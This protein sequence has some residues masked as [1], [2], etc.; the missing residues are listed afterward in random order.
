[1]RIFCVAGVSLCSYVKSSFLCVCTIVKRSCHY[2][3]IPSGCSRNE[4]RIYLWFLCEGFPV[5][6][7]FPDEQFRINLIFSFTKVHRKWDI[8]QIRNW[9]EITLRPHRLIHIS[10]YVTVIHHSR[11]W[12]KFENTTSPNLFLLTCVI[13]YYKTYYNIIFRFTKIIRAFSHTKVLIEREPIEIL[14]RPSWVL[15]KVTIY[16][17][18]TREIGLDFHTERSDQETLDTV[19]NKTYNHSDARAN[20]TGRDLDYTGDV[21]A[22]KN[23]NTCIH[24]SKQVG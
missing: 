10:F 20:R 5:V 14:L 23:L 15:W 9:N 22:S 21:E 7:I 19:H 17:L 1:M 11:S 18:R 13:P 16:I 2:R 4:V 24:T 8:H 3:I 12:S 6:Q